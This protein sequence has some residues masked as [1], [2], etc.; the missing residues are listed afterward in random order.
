MHLLDAAT[1]E[2]MTFWTNRI[3]GNIAVGQLSDQVAFMRRVRPG[4]VPVIALEAKDMPTQF[5][6]TKPRPHFKVLGWKTRDGAGPE[7]L[8]AGPEQTDSEQQTNAEPTAKE[9]LN[10]DLAF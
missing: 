3:G 8:L 2:I 7:R 1:G 9:L 5:G 4:A 6:G 10:D